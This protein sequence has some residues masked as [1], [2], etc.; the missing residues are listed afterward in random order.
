MKT[1]VIF[2]KYKNGDV[3][4][5]FPEIPSDMNWNHCE[6]Y[7]HVGQHGAADPYKVVSDTRPAYPSEYQLLKEE[8]DGIGY[9]LDVRQRISRAMVDR[10]LSCLIYH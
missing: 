2:R 10:R 6:S 8:L 7:M 9:E 5:I 4:A 3:I 1:V